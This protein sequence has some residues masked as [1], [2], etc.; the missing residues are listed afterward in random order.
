M[1]KKRGRPFERG[2]ARINRRG[3]PQRVV[4]DLRVAAR[5]FTQTALDVLAAVAVSKRASA[6]ARVRAA[7]ELLAFGWGEPA[8][9][10]SAT[11]EQLPPPGPAPSL[12]FIFVSKR[13]DGSAIPDD[14]LVGYSR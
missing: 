14:E 2:D 6:V 10:V 7:H 3:R 8:Q 1:A 11:V 12:K 13:P 9:A 5:E 4:T